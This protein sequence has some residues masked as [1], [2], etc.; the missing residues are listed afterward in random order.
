MGSLVP[1]G[2][3]SARSTDGDGLL[4]CIR[5]GEHS[6]SAGVEMVTLREP[7]PQRH[8]TLKVE[9]ARGLVVRS[10]KCLASASSTRR[11]PHVRRSMADRLNDTGSAVSS[12]DSDPDRIRGS[13]AA[14]LPPCALPIGASARAQRRRSI[15]APASP[16]P[17]VP[18]PS[19]GSA[20][21]RRRSSTVSPGLR[22]PV[23]RRRG[24]TPPDGSART[25][26]LVTLLP[27]NGCRRASRWSSHPIRRDRQEL[28]RGERER[29]ARDLEATS[30]RRQ[31][32]SSTRPV[33]GRAAEERTV[34]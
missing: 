25:P 14:P 26:Q 29:D 15:P 12:S 5:T 17:T 9:A 7:Q 18:T 8:E 3:A 32:P 2:A 28:R 6:R 10:G 33:V 20:S 27:R 21:D 34:S 16:A 22:P 11:T 1:T 19:P 13:E 4:S 24:E 30:P 23:R 31:D